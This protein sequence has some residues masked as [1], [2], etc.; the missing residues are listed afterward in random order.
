MSLT[1]FGGLASTGLPNC[2]HPQ[3]VRSAVGSLD[4]EIRKEALYRPCGS[5]YSCRMRRVHV[6]AGQLLAEHVHPQVSSHAAPGAQIFL[7]LT[8]PDEAVPRTVPGPHD[9]SR[10]P[11]DQD[12]PYCGPFLRTTPHRPNEGT[13]PQVLTF[14]GPEF[15]GLPRKAAYHRNSFR[16]VPRML[17]RAELF[18]E[19]AFFLRHAYGWSDEQVTQWVKGDYPSSLTLD[20]DHL[21]HFRMRLTTFMGRH[22]PD[23]PMFRFAATG[24]YGDLRARPHFHVMLFGW[25]TTRHAIEYL[26]H[27]WRSYH[28]NGIV[29]PDIHAAVHEGALQLVANTAAARYQAKDLVKSRRVLRSS[30]ELMARALPFV[31]QSTEPP[32]GSGAY[33]DWLE[34]VVLPAIENAGPSEVEQA[35]A[36]RRAYLVMPL[37]LGGHVELF[38][39]GDHMRQQVKALFSPE[40][41]EEATHRLNAEAAEQHGCND[42]SKE[43]IYV[44]HVKAVAEKNRCLEERAVRRKRERSIRLLSSRVSPRHDL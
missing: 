21:T 14:D 5:C 28:H 41:W 29:Y 34:K 15:E 17:S 12:Q 43:A 39:T 9:L 13:R 24:E 16:G 1:A 27:A 6:K 22:Y 42:P 37:F 23:W 31:R 40:V 20:G 19:Q 7:T 8:Y 32:L 38:T 3:K 44:E 30:P 18:E 2:E 10:D 33:I 35:I 26:F 25:P 36:A 4:G 11:F